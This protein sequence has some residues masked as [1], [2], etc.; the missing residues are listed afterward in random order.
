[1]TNRVGDS[2]VVKWLS[3]QSPGT[4]A[5][6]VKGER[7]DSYEHPYGFTAIRIINNILPGWNIRIHMWPPH[8]IQNYRLRQN[9]TLNQQVHAHGW[10]IWSAVMCGEVEECSFRVAASNGQRF[11]LYSVVTDYKS[12]V[13]RLQLMQGSVEAHL[14]GRELR[15]ASTS[16]YLIPSWSYHVTTGLRDRW[17]VT[18]VATESVDDPS[19]RLIAPMSTG[20]VTVNQRKASQDLGLL[21]S[22][23]G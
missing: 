5:S 14:T 11:G 7:V 20:A 13:S 3:V 19:S 22:L 18:L 21:N 6:I 23:L 12:M 17:S 4:V 2:G 9:K 1:M 15:T 8:E 10:R 16:P